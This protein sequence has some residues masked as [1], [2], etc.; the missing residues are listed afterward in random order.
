MPKTAVVDATELRQLLDYDQDTGLLRWRERPEELFATKRAYRAWNARYAGGPAFT[1]QNPAGY[2]TG[3]LF[4]RWH[5]AHRVV[6]AWAHGVWPEHQIDHINRIRHDNRLVNL[7]EVT[8][9]ENAKNQSVPRSS[10]TGVLGVSRLSLNEGRYEYWSARIRINGKDIRLG[11]FPFTEAGFA[12]AVRAR[13]EGERLHGFCQLGE[14][15]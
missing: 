14:S 11:T 2:L 7:R 15:R 4:G 5:A 12:A 1:C 8:N 9:A 3:Q 13:K 6:W 10:R